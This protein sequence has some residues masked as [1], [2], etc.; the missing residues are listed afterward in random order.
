MSIDMHMTIG[1]V[2]LAYPGLVEDVRV[3]EQR[4]GDGEV[5]EGDGVEHHTS[6]HHRHEHC[7]ARH[8]QRVRVLQVVPAQ[9]RERLRLLQQLLPSDPPPDPAPRLLRRVPLLPPFSSLRLGVSLGRGSP[10]L[11]RG[12]GFFYDA[13]VAGGRAGRNVW[14]PEE[15]A[16][17]RR[18]PFAK[19]GGHALVPANAA[20]VQLRRGEH[21]HLSLD[22]AQEPHGPRRHHPKAEAAEQ[23][24][25]AGAHHLHPRDLVREL[26]A[27][28]PAR[29]QREHVRPP[30]LGLPRQAGRDEHHHGHEAHEVRRVERG[31]AGGGGDELV[32]VQHGAPP[33]PAAYRAVRPQLLPLLPLPQVS[34]RGRLRLRPRLE[35]PGGG[36]RLDPVAAAESVA[37]E[38]QQEQHHAGL[39][40]VRHQPPGGL[41]QSHAHVQ[42]QEPLRGGAEVQEG[43]GDVE[44]T[45]EVDSE[46]RSDRVVR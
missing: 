12:G 42:P 33:Q 36:G 26:Q 10:G 8:A 5:D 22:E 46:E 23:P 27:H 41:L 39:Q 13:A 20:P 11:L 18:R 31:V 43:A 2:G 14:R 44:G 37:V 17:L 6:S 30:V 16:R 24:G 34:H 25:L 32:G 28:H 45:E 15:V 38:L 40:Q 4:G 3:V 21:E 29:Q 19:G 7:Q 9:L 35:H 1:S